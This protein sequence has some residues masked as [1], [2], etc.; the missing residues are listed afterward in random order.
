ML[1]FCI[2][3][4]FIHKHI[5]TGTL[6]QK[7]KRHNEKCSEKSLSKIERSERLFLFGN[8]Q[9]ITSKDVRADSKMCKKLDYWSIQKKQSKQ[10][11]HTVGTLSSASLC[12]DLL[13]LHTLRSTNIKQICSVLDLKGLLSCCCCLMMVVN[14]VGVGV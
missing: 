10:A 9:N 14:D 12:F 1:P 2:L 6:F 8:I 4:T 13:S 7:R 3:C 5:T 11:K